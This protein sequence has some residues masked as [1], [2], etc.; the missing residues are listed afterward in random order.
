ME[1][2]IIVSK[3]AIIMGSK[4]WQYVYGLTNAEKDAIKNGTTVAF[5]TETSWKV[6]RHKTSR[7]FP[8]VPSSDVLAVLEQLKLGVGEV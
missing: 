2:Q 6:V 4:G 1:K 7:Y 3:T 5:R 8:R